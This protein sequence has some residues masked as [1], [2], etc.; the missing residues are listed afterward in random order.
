LNVF[1]TTTH[2]DPVSIFLASAKIDEPWLMQLET[3]LSMLQQKG[4]ISLW[5]KRL[6]IAGTDWAKAIEEHIERA[7][8]ILSLGVLMGRGWLVRAMMATCT[9]G[10]QKGLC[11]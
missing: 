9:F 11:R 4:L 1:T 7:T 10:Q 2:Q 8:L 5:H 3:H 6:I